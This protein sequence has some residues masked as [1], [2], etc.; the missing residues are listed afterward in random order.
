MLLWFVCNSNYNDV[1]LIR[2]KTVATYFNSCDERR[3]SGEFTPPC[4]SNGSPAEGLK[5]TVA[6]VLFFYTANLRRNIWSHMV[7]RFSAFIVRSVQVQ[8]GWL[9]WEM[10]DRLA[11][12][13]PDQMFVV[14]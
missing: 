4:L 1:K 12:Q 9:T 11:V 10:T 7:R 5:Q 14:R 2:L 8:A 13:T 3:R 6:K